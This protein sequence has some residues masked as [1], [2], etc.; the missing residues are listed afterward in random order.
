MAEQ[1]PGA[2]QLATAVKDA[3]A[4]NGWRQAD[5]EP[6]SRETMAECDPDRQRVGL[7]E[8]TWQ[9]IWRGKKNVEMDSYS[10]ATIDRTLD[11]P[12]GTA[13]ALHH[14]DEPPAAKPTRVEEIEARLEA[15]EARQ[16]AEWQELRAQLRG[17]AELIPL[18]IGQRRE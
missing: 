18:I 7:S 10:Y 9:D 5:L 11:W 2:K 16:T 15:L 12:A 14:G 4:R 17:I 6:K 1:V 13:W 3:T 8:R